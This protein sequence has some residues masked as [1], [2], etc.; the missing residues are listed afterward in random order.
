M[1]EKR[2]Q[3]REDVFFDLVENA[4][5]LIQVVS[6][7]GKYLYVNKTWEEKLG[8]T[9]EEA[10]QL[11][12]RDIILPDK[13]DH[14]LFVFN[15]L[16]TRG[17]D[18]SI[19]TV[20]V[21]KD[22]TQ[23]PVSGSMSVRKEKGKPIS[24]RG[25]FRDETQKKKD[26][27][28]LRISRQR[29]DAIF[30]SSTLG[31]ALADIQGNF[32]TINKTFQKMLGYK[33]GELVG[34]N[35]SEITHPDD[36]QSNL[37]GREDFLKNDINSYSTEKRYMR[38]NGSAIWVQISVSKVRDE[39]GKVI[40]ILIVIEN[41]N[42]RKTLETKMIRTNQLQKAI[43]DSANL[44]IISLDKN[45]IIQAYNKTA[46]KLL[47]YT[48]EEMIGNPKPPFH[49]VE[50]LR[51]RTKELNQELGTNFKVGIDTFVG[52]IRLTKKPDEYELTYIS[53]SGERIPML[54]SA[55]PIFDKEGN[56]NGYM[57]IGFDLRERKQALETR[58]EYEQFF[59][60][61]LD[62][63]CLAGL[64][65][66]F[67]KVN[68]AFTRILGHSAEDLV[69]KP[70]V[71]FV[72]P[73][74]Q[75]K[76]LKEL[77]NLSEGKDTFD[78]ENRYLCKDG[79]YK[80]MRWVATADLE[81]GVLYAVAHDSSAMKA[82]EQALIGSESRLKEAE[83]IAKL[84]YWEF[85]FKTEQLKWSDEVF[86]IFE[87]N[88]NEVE[89]TEDLYWN[90]V[91]PDDV[92]EMKAIVEESTSKLESY[93]LNHRIV[94]V[95]GLVKHV[96][97][98][99]Y[100]ISKDGK[101]Q[102]VIG[103]IQDVTERTK[104][105]REL[106][107]S[108]IFAEA[109]TKQ[110]PNLI[111]I[112][113]FNSQTYVYANGYMG[114]DPAYLKNL[115]PKLIDELVHPD[116]QRQM[117]EHLKELE[118]L[119]DGEAYQ[120]EQRLLNIKGEWRWMFTRET[121]FLR[122]EN[123]KPSQI[124]GVAVDITKRKKTEEQLKRLSLVADKI[125]N[126]VVIADSKGKVEWI[127]NSF[128]RIT[129]YSINE[130]K[131][132]H[133]SEVMQGPGTNMAEVKKMWGKQKRHEAYSFEVLNYRKD[134]QPIWLSV[135]NTP[136]MENGKFAGK[137][138]EI[139]LDITDKK[140]TEFQLIK[141]KEQA[142]RS[143]RIKDEFLANMSHEIR[144]PMNAVIGFTNLLLDTELDED[145]L[146]SV[147]TIHN[148][149]ENL[150]I[151]INEILNFS[152]IESGKIEIVNKELN[153][154]HLMTE[155]NNLFDEKARQ[156]KLELNFIISSSVPEMVIGD[157]VRI[158]QI[159]VNLIN[160]A[161]KFTEKG[162]ITVKAKTLKSTA[163]NAEIEFSVKDTGIGIPKNKIKK[164]FESF[165]QAETDT[166]RRYGGTGLGLTIVKR[167]VEMQNGNLDVQS[168][169]NE[170]SEFIF[171]LTYG[172]PAKTKKKKYEKAKVSPP[173]N[174]KGY[175]ILL[176]ED[177]EMNRQLSRAIL[178]KNYQA[179]M[180]AASNGREGL[181]MLEKRKYDLILMDIQMPEMD[182]IEASQKIRNSENALIRNIPIIALTA[183]VME[184]EK[185]RCIEAGMNDFIAKPFRKED[186][187]A[188]ILKYA[189]RPRKD[190]ELIYDLSTLND[191]S[192]GDQS[193]INDM[194]A[195]FIKNTPGDLELLQTF[196]KE[197]N[198]T[199][200]KKL[201]HKMKSSLGFVGIKK[202]VQ[203]ASQI[204]N[205]AGN[206]KELVPELTKIC[207]LAMEQVKEI[208]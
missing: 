156:K 155:L 87:I 124:L 109:I 2:F 108:K 76:T 176:F 30:N 199:G 206:P 188:K 135:N 146:K 144:T 29:F 200:L 85:D 9:K 181:E 136:V 98:L 168:K 83:R 68:P 185:K 177:N 132:K 28:Q 163:E 12:F 95:S 11:H 175:R 159:L 4:T 203:L 201:A 56:I 15:K 40:N 194:I 13:L 160:N 24:T 121:I 18:A 25:I 129:G 71:E 78:F 73:D 51:Q 147:E 63:F 142:E 46:E 193:F 119:K 23:F 117:R 64:D 126:G 75:N 195:T 99:A 112:V 205:E 141:A 127:N 122:D 105:L 154:H 19:E 120:Y 96:T 110:S 103:T 157:E 8:Y 66:Y 34:H 152:K 20:F 179:K 86:R 186:L 31:V 182:G 139:V 70:F 45:G 48:A 167:L 151:I 82:N 74:D 80:W 183:D 44:T 6:V 27:E 55:S 140:K 138:V 97:E 54:L 3:P 164:I 5:D 153:L 107:Q 35:F 53:K 58:R 171:S 173:Q 50:E 33:T 170:G 189:K 143:A 180:D 116:D 130:L 60:M 94:T 145:Q 106:E 1:A 81:T 192:G 101:L 49:D 202:G 134:G 17:K 133:P 197:D 62:M 93:T 161:I 92:K 204:E 65:G 57:G 79:S 38:K 7:E 118:T 184:K 113:D 26:E 84:G 89:M 104:V 90:R 169:L 72:H 36:L 91:H 14:C 61:S 10:A 149:G 207:E 32:T 190:R 208:I 16:T 131:G 22:G 41:I 187:L 59:S 148:A 150:L 77:E 178:E 172:L 52:K 67:K 125:D 88:R 21:A 196:L 100:P 102:K 37:E 115:G 191:I 137:Y 123:G 158:N 162:A 198:K 43:L 174:L 69:S 111:Y 165:T 128:T 39:Q 166:T 114:F 42:E 47:G